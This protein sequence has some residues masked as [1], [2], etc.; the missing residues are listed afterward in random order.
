MKLPDPEQ[1]N[2]KDGVVGGDDCWLITPK[3]MATDWSDD[4]KHFRSIIITKNEHKIVSLGMKKFVNWG[5]KPDF[6]PWDNNWKFNAYTKVDGS[7]LIISKYRDQLICRTRGT[8]DAR[9][10]A[11]G[12]E[13]DELI[14]KYPSVF[15]NHYLDSEN[16]SI[17]CEWTTPNNIVVLKEHNE[18]T[19]TLLGLIRHDNLKYLNQRAVD[20]IAV[21]WNINRPKEHQ[22]DSV[23]ECIEDVKLWEG[24][25]GVVIY[26]IES[27]VGPSSN[28]ILKK[29]KADLY[30][31]LHSIA[32]GIKNVNNVLDIFMESPRFQSSKDFYNYIETLLSYEVAEKCKDFIDQICEA[33]TKVQLK[34]LAV[35]GSIDFIKT[36]ETRKE[37]AQYIMERCHDWMIPY[38]FSRLDN[39]ELDD[40]LLR[41]AMEHELKI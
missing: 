10:L 17:H 29:I 20:Q 12:F 14:K 28:Q 39:K 41:K 35:D 6:E 30:L 27:N 37:Q 16:W 34:M 40:K 1:F 11:N 23:R 24:I 7:L 31:A 33:Y 22:Y 36:L 26:S 8:Y 4:N 38:A 21:N 5:E 19:L 13:I 25:E 32:T 9:Q 15:D 2:F 3:N 18:P